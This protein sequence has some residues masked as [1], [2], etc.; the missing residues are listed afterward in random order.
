MK[1]CTSNLAEYIIIEDFLSNTSFPEY[2]EKPQ[3]ILN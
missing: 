1:I 3:P 2:G